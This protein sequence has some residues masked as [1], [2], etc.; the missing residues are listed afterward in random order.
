ML[1]SNYFDAVKVANMLSTQLKLSYTL[2]YAT[3]LLFLKGSFQ[4]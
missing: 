1:L 3:L 4:L 2:F